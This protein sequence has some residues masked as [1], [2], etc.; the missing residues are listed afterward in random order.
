MSYEIMSDETTF[1]KTVP[2]GP[3]YLTLA[4]STFGSSGLL[5]ITPQ[6]PK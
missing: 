3:S 6:W 5:A 2:Y 1:D 4:L